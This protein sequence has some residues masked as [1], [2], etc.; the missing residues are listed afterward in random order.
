[1]SHEGTSVVTVGEL[2]H[3]GNP[4]TDRELLEHLPVVATC[5]LDLREELPV[6]DLR[7]LVLVGECPI[8]QLPNTRN[9]A[10]D[11][12]PVI[13]EGSCSRLPLTGVG[14]VRTVPCRVH[15]SLQLIIHSI[16]S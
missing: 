7:K 1:M 14:V 12:Y 4:P 6:C 9:D 2:N 11:R 15:R 16:T 13:Y 8:R 10:F 5:L 3:G